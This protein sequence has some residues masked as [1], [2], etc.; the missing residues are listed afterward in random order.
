MTGM[1]DS[2][3][4]RSLH[5]LRCGRDDELCCDVKLAKNLVNVFALSALWASL[6]EGESNMMPNKHYFSLPLGE[7]LIEY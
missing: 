7:I 4:Q 2:K 3:V 1:V 5:S 6:P